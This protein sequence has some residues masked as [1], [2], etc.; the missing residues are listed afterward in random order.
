MEGRQYIS[1][2]CRQ[3]FP[4]RR[5]ADVASCGETVPQGRSVST[6]YAVSDKG[7]NVNISAER[8][9]YRLCRPYR[10]AAHDTF[11]L[12]GEGELFFHHHHNNH[13][14]QKNHSSD[15]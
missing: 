13:P 14:N 10:V 5:S 8:M 6:R 2:K 11:L 9:I 3:L 1:H 7:Q 15:N 12:T 4:A